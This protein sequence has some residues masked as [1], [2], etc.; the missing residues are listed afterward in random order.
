[1]QSNRA[2]TGP[3]QHKAMSLLSQRQDHNTWPPYV[4]DR[5]TG[6]LLPWAE[7]QCKAKEAFHK[8]PQ[9]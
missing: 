3:Q 7:V 6:L 5:V 8:E 4:S 1:M 2:H 9:S